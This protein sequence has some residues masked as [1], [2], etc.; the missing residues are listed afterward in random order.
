MWTLDKELPE[1]SL[2]RSERDRNSAFTLYEGR[3]PLWLS[4]ATTDPGIL[5][6]RGDA[7]IVSAEAHI[8]AVGVTELYRLV[9]RERQGGGCANTRAGLARGE[10]F[11]PAQAGGTAEPEIAVKGEPEP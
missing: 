7:L 3:Q 2:L 11:Y 8:G 5:P 4:K 9:F 1:A 10:I 6:C